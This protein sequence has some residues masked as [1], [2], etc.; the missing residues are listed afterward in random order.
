MQNFVLGYFEGGTFEPTT[1]VTAETTDLL[2]SY[3]RLLQGLELVQWAFMPIS[4]GMYRHIP[5]QTEDELGAELD[6][7]ASDPE[8][9]SFSPEDYALVRNSPP[10]SCRASFG[11]SFVQR[12]SWLPPLPQLSLQPSPPSLLTQSFGT[13]TPRPSRLV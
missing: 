13:S 10:C 8:E 3:C 6:M 11:L 5:H 4:A 7:I 1:R 2:V 12:T 9:Y